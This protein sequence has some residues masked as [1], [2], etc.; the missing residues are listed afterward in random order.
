MTEKKKIFVTGASGNTGRHALRHLCKI[1]RLEI[2]AGVHEESDVKVVNEICPDIVMHKIDADRLE[3]LSEAMLGSSDVFIIPSQ[4]ENKV[5]HG[6]TCIM[7]AKKA[8]VGFILLLSVI[9]VEN[10]KY[11]QAEEFKE[12]EATLLQA[13]VDKWCILRSGF[14]A[15]NFMLYKKQIQ[16]G[17]LPVPIGEG[18]FAPVDA[19][20]VGLMASKILENCKGHTKKI[21]QVTGPRSLTGN[22][23]AISFSKLL[24]R[25][26]EFVDINVEEA[27]KIL[28]DQNIP[29]SDIQSM[30][31]F[32]QMVKQY[33]QS[34]FVDD[35]KKV[36]SSEPSYIER[37]IERHK[38]ELQSKPY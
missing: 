26:I 35:F 37:Y 1:E 16:E 2:H 28:Q 27:E 24:A 38:E 36:A 10:P 20:D 19:E 25:K 3:S 15:Q 11:L 32:Y 12:I 9:G 13:S 8:K 22:E 4:G 6:K 29:A 23:M 17:K 34:R 31:E 7:A 33:S 14:Y 30:I 21:Y 18:S 5:H